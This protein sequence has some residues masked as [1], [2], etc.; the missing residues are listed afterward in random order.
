MYRISGCASKYLIWVFRF[1][2]RILSVFQKCFRC[3]ICFSLFIDAN[4]A[5]AVADRQVLQFAPK[6]DRL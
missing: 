4:S 2:L 6:M 1:I 5:R 3:F